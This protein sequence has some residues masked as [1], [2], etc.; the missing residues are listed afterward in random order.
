VGYLGVEYIRKMGSRSLHIYQKKSVIKSRIR[1]GD[2]LDL[3]NTN[4]VKSFHVI[5]SNGSKKN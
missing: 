3:S 2:V 1:F 4:K 5:I